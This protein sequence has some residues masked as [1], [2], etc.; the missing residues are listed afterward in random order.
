MSDMNGCGRQFR[1]IFFLFI[2]SVL[3][4]VAI[5]F[6][7]GEIAFPLSAIIP[8]IGH[9]DTSGG[10]IALGQPVNDTITQGASDDWK[11]F[12]EQGETVEISLVGGFDT[13]LELYDSDGRELARDDDGGDGLNSLI[14]AQTLPYTGVY[15]IIVRA[16][17]SRSEGGW[18]TLS[19][20]SAVPSELR[21]IEYG[22]TI[23]GTVD[24][25]GGARFSFRGEAGDR[26]T[27]DMS[28]AGGDAYL[29]LY[30]SD[31]REITRDDDGGSGLDARIRATLDRA[32]NYIIQGRAYS[33]TTGGSYTLTL[34]RE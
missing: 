21:R 13:F 31:G 27:I 11:F 17:S 5:N 23:T 15:R 10:D 29:I 6:F 25:C 19:V 9:P 16:Y 24:Q 2:L 14:C 1:S 33:S 12:A 26:M 22:E 3:I 18:Y 8:G 7:R 34:S 30:D 28:I 20:N 32:D 4:V